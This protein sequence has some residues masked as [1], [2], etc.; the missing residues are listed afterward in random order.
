MV[1]FPLASSLTLCSLAIVVF[2][3]L[4]STVSVPA[5]LTQICFVVQRLAKRMGRKPCEFY[6]W[7][8]YAC[9][10]QQVRLLSLMLIKMCNDQ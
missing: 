10:N 3:A 9:I 2:N 5:L 8:D 1:L 4:H 6:L 7:I